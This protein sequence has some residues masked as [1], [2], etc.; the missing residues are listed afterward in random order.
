M[1]K[2][3][4]A[5]KLKLYLHIRLWLC[6]FDFFIDSISL[7]FKIRDLVATLIQLFSVSGKWNIL[8]N[9]CINV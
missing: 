4:R 5:I 9:K 6:P 8:F 3:I 2:D 7:I 1:Q